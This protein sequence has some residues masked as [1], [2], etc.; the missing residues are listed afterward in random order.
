[1]KSITVLTPT[2][3]RAGTL[4][5]VYE[6]LLNQSD[7][8]FIWLIVDDGSTDNTEEIVDIWSKEKKI[9]IEY[10]KIK[11]GGQHKALQLGYH[12]ARTKYLVKIDSDDA[13]IPDAIQI[14]KK[15]WSD[16]EVN[17]KIGNIAALSVYDNGELDGKW[18]FPPNVEYI[19]SFWHEMVLRKNNHNELS[20]CTLTSI[21]QEI[22]PL[23][24]KF[25]LEDKT[26][27][28]DAVF[29]P[30]IGRKCL[31][32]YIK[33]VVQIVY[34]DAPFSSLRSMTEY[35]NKFW[36]V[37]LDNKYFLDENINYF[38]WNPKYFINLALKLTISCI[39]CRLPFR[40]LWRELLSPRLKLLLIL[41]YPASILALVYFKY[42]KKKYW[43]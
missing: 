9:D 20:N 34:V 27:I 3:N 10:Y 22:Y 43:I 2:Y 14:Y 6:S 28:I 7:Q 21:L 29:A 36:K 1:M 38:F 13:F 19:D 35:K 39:L 12:K 40:E 24:Y 30:R 31:T 17:S 41:L 16:A 42:V 8:D 15:A 5:R 33:S 25:W 18:H 37:I 4:P 26:N 11:K 23:E 32:R